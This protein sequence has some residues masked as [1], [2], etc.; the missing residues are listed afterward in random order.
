[1]GSI[2]VVVAVVTNLRDDSQTVVPLDDFYSVWS[3]G[4]TI[5]SDLECTV[6]LHSS[7][8]PPVAALMKAASNHKFFQLLPPG[9]KLPLNIADYPLGQRVDYSPV[10]VGHFKITFSEERREYQ[11]E[12]EAQDWDQDLGPIT[13]DQIKALHP[14]SHYQLVEC[15]SGG[16]FL[17]SRRGRVYVLEGRAHYKASDVSLWIEAGQYINHPISSFD[18]DQLEIGTRMM[19]VGCHVNAHTSSLKISTP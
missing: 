18:I 10:Q 19:L 7:E 15:H 13:I 11:F 14:R 2:D 16:D 1:M 3:Q 4:I 9:T 8:I 17:G 12:V 6:V 5:G